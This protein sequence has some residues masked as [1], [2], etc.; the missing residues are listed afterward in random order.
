MGYASGD[1]LILPAPTRRT[2][3]LEYLDG[4][5]FVGAEVYVSMY[6]SSENH[7]DVAV[8]VDLGGFKT[9]AAGEISFV[10]TDSPIALTVGYFEPT[11]GGPAGTMFAGHSDVILG[12]ERHIIVKRLWKLPQYDYVLWLRAPDKGP[13]VHAR[14][15]ACDNFDGCGVGCG[16]IAGTPASDSMGVMRFRENDLREMRSLT[17]VSAAGQERNLTR[18]E[19][20]ELLTKHRIHLVW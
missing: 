5:P 16:P 12:G 9:D 10:A 3:R 2:V 17:V 15:K 8:G 19:L 1:A 13:I 18:A 6:G 7:C 11:S 14:I 20:S 4:K